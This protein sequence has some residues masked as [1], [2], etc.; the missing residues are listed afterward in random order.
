[1]GDYPIITSFGV[2]MVMELEKF[3]DTLPVN[4]FHLA[5]AVDIIDYLFDQ[6]VLFGDY[7]SEPH[8]PVLE[9]AVF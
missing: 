9:I 1:M 2:V 4:I 6:F 7:I 3:V 5:A 8:L